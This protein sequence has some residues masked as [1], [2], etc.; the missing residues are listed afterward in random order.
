M[1][2]RMKHA[3]YMALLG[4]SLPAAFYAQEQKTVIDDKY[5]ESDVVP[6][7]G[8][9]GFSFQTK[10]GDFL[11]KPYALVQVSGKFNYYDDEGLNLA[12]QDNIA[13]SGFAIPNAILGFSGKAF[14]KVTFNFALNASQSGGALLQQAWF[15]VNMKDE[16]RLRVGK[17]KTPYN[18]AY[19]VTLGETLFPVLPSSLTTGVNLDKSLNATKPNISTGFDIGVQLHGIFN[20]RWG[21]QVGIFNGTGISTNEATKTTSDDHKWL[22]SLLY[23]ARMAYM[24]HGVM[25]AHQGNPED[26]QND[27]ML[28]AVSGSWNVEAEDESSDDLRAGVEFAWLKNRW[29]LSTEAYL[30]QMNFTERMQD[31]SNFTSW[32]GYVQG[33]YFAT[34]KLQLIGRYDYFDRNGVN[35]KGSLNMPA[36]GINYFFS[37]YNLKLQAMYQYI[38]RW[39][40]NTQDDRDA[41]DNGMAMHSAVVMLQYSF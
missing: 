3:F 24:P 28:F 20:N 22:P 26:L 7:A 12:D 6:L 40:H 15:D 35:K 1:N 30:L 23:A 33:G 18:Q 32:G 4:I 14:G 9:Q 17:F 25:P 41:D 27:K 11:F 13:N 16:L 39:G 36:V 10:S 38:G 19:L 21:Y 31:A 8:K 5:V 2:N 29:Y 37:N 34:K